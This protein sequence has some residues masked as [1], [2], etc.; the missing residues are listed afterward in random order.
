MRKNIFEILSDFD[1]GKEVDD[2]WGLFRSKIVHNK[3][4][5]EN[6]GIVELVNNYTFSF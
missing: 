5:H 3:W 4:S 1:L 2:I 6:E